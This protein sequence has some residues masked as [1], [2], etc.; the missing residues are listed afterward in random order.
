[1]ISAAGKHGALSPLASTT[2][3][4]ASMIVENDFWGTCCPGM[5]HSSEC[6]KCSR[7]RATWTGNN[8][9]EASTAAM[10]S[11]VAWTIWATAAKTVRKTAFHRR[12]AGKLTRGSSK[13]KLAHQ[14]LSEVRPHLPVIFG[15]TS[16]LNVCR[17]LAIILSSTLARRKRLTRAATNS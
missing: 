16:L 8:P 12:V 7:T 11:S 4:S 9:S 14:R 1:M 15:S 6:A 3:P 2:R 17:V 10:P 13:R 5:R